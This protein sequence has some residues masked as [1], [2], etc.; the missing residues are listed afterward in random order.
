MLRLLGGVLVR[1]PTTE[2]GRAVFCLVWE[3]DGGS[4]EG[5]VRTDDL[6][7]VVKIPFMLC[8]FFIGCCGR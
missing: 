7:Y 4:C 2:V 1:S 5:A 6:V 3:V 8:E